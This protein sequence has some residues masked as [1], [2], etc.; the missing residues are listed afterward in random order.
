MQ[1]IEQMIETLWDEGNWTA[2]LRVSFDG[3]WNASV[4]DTES[5]E[6]LLCPAGEWFLSTRGPDTMEDAVS[7]LEGRI[8]KGL[9]QMKNQILGLTA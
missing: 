3:S 1:H 8:K 2:E 7:V 4:I 6:V 9:A 5:E